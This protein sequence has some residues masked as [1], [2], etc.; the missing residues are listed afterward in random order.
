MKSKSFKGGYTFKRFKGKPLDKVINLDMPRRVIIPMSQGFGGALEPNVKVG[1][2]VNAG[3]IIA[4][5]DKKISSPIHSSI[6][7]KVTAI[8][9]MNYFKREV[10]MVVI[11]GDGGDGYR[12]LD[13]ANPNW[14]R[15]SRE[16]IE[17]L[18]Y[19]SGITSVD[20]EGIPTRYKSSIIVPDNVEDLIVH[21]VGSEVFNSSLK[22]LLEGKKL[23]N[24]IEGMKILKKIMPKARIHLALNAREKA[25]IERIKKLTSGLDNFDIYPV[26]SKYPQGYDEILIPTLLG[27]K[28]PYGY[29]AANIGIVV[30][31]IQAVVQVHEAVAYG[32]PL[33]ERTIALCGPSFKEPLHVKVRVGTPLE[34]V[35]SGRL[36]NAASRVILNSLLSGFELKDLA[37]PIDRTFSQIVA[38]PEDCDRKFLAFLRPGF[39]SDSY[40]NAFASD[41]VKTKKHA[42]TNCHGEERPCIQCGY[43]V[44]VCPVKIYPTTLNGYAERAINETLMRYGIFN[45]IDCNLCSYVCPSK[46]PLARNLREA[47]SKLIETGCDHSLC[48]LPKFDL[49]GLQEYKGVKVTR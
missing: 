42:E 17:E 29:S 48:I 20:R 40:S 34:F 28:F 27:K 31:N 11:E 7:G 44:E 22:V 12:E 38:I 45:C 41:F 43:C 14:E 46:I 36:K 6:N 23:F 25:L 5:D 9:R 37:L 33:I 49:M 1:D 13:G 47:K 3:Q 10:T 15:L 18:L 8:E 26:V 21:G 35:L 16:K 24:L 4:R 39:R 30:L 19:L 2:D 32:K